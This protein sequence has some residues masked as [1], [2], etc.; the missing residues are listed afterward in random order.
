MPTR[1]T[2]FGRKAKEELRIKKEATLNDDELFVLAYIM[3]NP[4][5]TTRGV[6]LYPLHQDLTYR[7]YTDVQAT[8]IL[9]GLEDKGIIK[10]IDVL[11]DDPL[12]EAKTTYPAYKVTPDGR[13]F[14]Q[15]NKELIPNIKSTYKYLIRLYDS[16]K[17]N[18]QFLEHIKNLD[19]VQGQTRFIT[20]DDKRLC[21]I[22]L[23]AYKAIDRK[24]IE[25]I[26]AIDKTKIYSFKEEV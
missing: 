25:H 14:I 9:T 13:R 3:T 12:K 26:A 10:Y 18:Q 15:Q 23:F 6:A 17:N 5:A 20:E 19:F 8:S 22:V 1:I 2:R 7:G 24:D 16:K 11:S 21:A 4:Q